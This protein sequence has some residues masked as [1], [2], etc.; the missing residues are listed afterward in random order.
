[1]TQAKLLAYI[2]GEIA[3]LQSPDVIGINGAVT[4]DKT[5]LAHSLYE[6][7]RK[8]GVHTQA[9]SIDDFHNPR[10]ADGG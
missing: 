5:F 1:M 10:D 2:V 3:K 8:K 6:C 9:L 4:A 7:L